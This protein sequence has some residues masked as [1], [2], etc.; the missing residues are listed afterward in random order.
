M[1]SDV[2]SIS[3][4]IT[5]GLRSSEQLQWSFSNLLAMQNDPVGKAL[6]PSSSVG[7][8]AHH[9]GTSSAANSTL[10]VGPS[11]AFVWILEG[12]KHYVQRCVC[13]QGGGTGGLIECTIFPP[14][15]F[16]VIPC[17]TSL[18]APSDP[19]TAPLKH[20][21]YKDRIPPMQPSL[22]GNRLLVFVPPPT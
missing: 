14:F 9:G 22:P 3:P 16:S 2:L 10:A 1:D 17:T 6:S 4:Q 20:L 5:L 11:C 8:G 15:F 13:G 18:T 12:G 19:P 7:G 21:L